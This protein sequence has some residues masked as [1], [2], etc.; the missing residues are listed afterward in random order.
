MYVEKF[1]MYGKKMSTQRAMD[2][3][4]T[5]YKHKVKIK[6]QMS[7]FYIFWNNNLRLS[8]DYWVLNES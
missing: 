8:E 2:F 7:T 4:K 3:I 5:E 1:M 6:E